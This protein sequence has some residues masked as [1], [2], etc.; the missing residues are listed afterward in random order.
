MTEFVKL[1]NNWIRKLNIKAKVVYISQ[2]C[3]SYLQ[4]DFCDLILVQ[5]NEETHKIFN[6]YLLDKYSDYQIKFFVPEENLIKFKTT[7]NKIDI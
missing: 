6:F 4:E 2:N 7:F 1:A 5:Y 3:E